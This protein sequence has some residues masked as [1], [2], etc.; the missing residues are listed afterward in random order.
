MKKYKLICCEI[1]Y[2]EIC[3]LVAESPA[4]CDVEFLPKG[5]HD[6]G[7]EKMLPRIQ[8][9]IDAIKEDEADAILLGYGLCNNGIVG[10]AARKIPLVVPRAHDCITLFMGSRQK[11]KEY[12]NAHPG[13]YYRTTGWCERSDSNVEGDQTVSQKLG[14]FL[15][16]EELVAKYGEENAKYIME[17]MGDPVAHYD[18]ITFIRMGLSCEDAFRAEA[19]REAE[20][21]GWQFEEIAGSMEILR[22]LIFGEWDEDF[23]IVPPGKRIIARYNDNIIDCE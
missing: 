22:K 10:L 23:L 20:E 17:T 18:R 21:K 2:R 19:K 4:R 13:T 16:Y 5:L 9:R 8:E 15:Q 11:Y 7:V 12:F 1:F 6:L 14:L 3:H